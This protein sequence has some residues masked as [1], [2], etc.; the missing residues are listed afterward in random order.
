MPIAIRC[1]GLT[2]VGLNSVC[3]RR[4]NCCHFVPWPDG[5]T[6]F[7]ACMPT[8]KAFRHFQALRPLAIKPFAAAPI[9]PQMELFL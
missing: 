1:A 8:G 5:G 3:Q 4:D 7:N 2:S 9:K 6:E